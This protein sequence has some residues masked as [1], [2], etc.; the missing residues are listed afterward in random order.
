MASQAPPGLLRPIVLG[1]SDALR[2]GQ[3]VLSIGNPFGFDH[4]LSTGVVSALNRDIVSA[5][6]SIAGGI[7]TDASINPGNSGG[8]LLDS[9]GRLVGVNTAIFTPTG[10]FTGIGFALPSRTVAKIVPELIQYGRVMRP[11]LGVQV[12]P[13]GVAKQLGFTDGAMVQAVAPDSPAAKAGI[14]PTR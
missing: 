14:L 8:A 12:A 7:Q 3:Q 11:S 4:S 6:T 13:A 1:D 5:G 10:V 9:S 2:V